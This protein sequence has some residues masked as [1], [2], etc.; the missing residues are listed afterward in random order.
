MN[1]NLLGSGMW[2]LGYD[3]DEMD[4][5]N[6]L[7]NKYYQFPDEYMIADFED[8]LGIFYSDLTYSGSTTGISSESIHEVDNGSMKL[9]LK[10][11]ASISND[12]TVRIL[13]NHG[14]KFLNRGFSE[15]GLI[16]LYLKTSGE[17]NKQ[18]AITVDDM[19]GG[20]EISDK[21]NIISDGNWHEYAWDFQNDH[22]NNFYMGNGKIDGPII[23]LDAILLFCPDQNEDWALNIDD[24]EYEIVS[25]GIEKL[26]PDKISLKQNYPNPFNG[27]TTIE[28]SVFEESNISLNVYNIRGQLVGE[29]VHRYHQPGSYRFRFSSGDFSSGVYIYKL[30]CNGT[31]KTGKMTI[32]K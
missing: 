13:A 2:A 7:A 10:D 18:I 31:V 11:D 1:N 30:I 19:A 27:Q 4:L 14:N 28:Y 25:S 5:W 16:K 6:L 21:I 24:I 9:L 23:S 17:S 29:L 20:N 3:D 12:W 26:T 32:L 22:W 15:E 8:T